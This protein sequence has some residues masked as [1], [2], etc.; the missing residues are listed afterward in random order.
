MPARSP[1]PALRTRDDVVRF[2]IERFRH[3]RLPVPQHVQIIRRLLKHARLAPNG[4]IVWPK[5]KSGNGYGK[6]NV[7]MFGQHFQLYVHQLAEYLGNNPDDVPKGMEVAHAECDNPPCFHPDHLKRQ[8]RRDNRQRSAERTNA[9]KRGEIPRDGEL[10][11][12]A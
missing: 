8:K 1:E 6:L 9:K 11:R 12:A 10:R 7:R 3:R 5:A 4:C 2:L